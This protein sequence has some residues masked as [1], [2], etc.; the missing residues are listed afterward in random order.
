MPAVS[1]KQRR[2]MAIAEHNPDQLYKRNKGALSMNKGQLHDF[3]STSEKGLAKKVRKSTKGSPP[4]TG[5]ELSKGYRSLGRG[6]P[7]PMDGK[8]HATD[9]RGEG[10]D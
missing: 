4:M 8:P 9:N 7:Q 1:K 6:F 2:M 10:S 3:A 5:S